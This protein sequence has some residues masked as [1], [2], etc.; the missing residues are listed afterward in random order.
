MD[1]E[2]RIIRIV[3]LSIYNL[4][5]VL[6]IIIIL[7]SAQEN[8]E[9]NVKPIIKKYIKVLII[10]NCLYGVVYTISSYFT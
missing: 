10:G 1:E 4:G 3:I 5:I 6:R 2:L 9:L 8:D 7:M